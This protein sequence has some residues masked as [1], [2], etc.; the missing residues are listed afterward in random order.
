MVRK[1]SKSMKDIPIELL[2]QLNEG[3]V[4]S[5]NL[6]EWLAVDQLKLLQNI[7]KENAKM[8][9]FH[10]ILSEING[11]KKKT[12]VAMNSTI[13]KGLLQQL[14]ANDD[15]DFEK[16]IADHPSDSVRCW[17]CYRIGLD[18]SLGHEEKLLKIHPFAKDG[19]FGVREIAWM[20]VRG[21]ISCHLEESIFLLTGW[22]K[23]ENENIRRFASEATR[24]RGVWCSH[25][26]Q[27]KEN[28]SLALPILEPL[29]SDPSKYVQNSVGNWLNDASKTRPD[30]VQKVYKDWSSGASKETSYILKRGLRTIHSFK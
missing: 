24:P 14:S 3:K 23:D 25:I 2:N 13:G 18:D 10:P 11:L 27:L 17:A 26:P 28:P 15:K 12:I 4:E 9:Y 1:G 22:V 7:L 19:H 21:S 8:D 20:A 5:A 16:V 29:K 6:V 30:F